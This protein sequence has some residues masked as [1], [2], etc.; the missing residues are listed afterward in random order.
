MN[1]INLPKNGATI[2][3]TKVP[4]ASY[5]TAGVE[6]HAQVRGS[7][8]KAYVH[9]KNAKTGSSTSDRGDAYRFAEFEEI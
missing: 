7:G 2:I 6:Y 8:R 5:A 1:G 9:L 3:F 4:L